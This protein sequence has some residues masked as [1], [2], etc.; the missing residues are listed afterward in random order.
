LYFK[1][2]NKK[3]EICIRRFISVNWS[4]YIYMKKSLNPIS[5]IQRLGYVRK[6]KRSVLGSWG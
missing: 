6:T 3:G 4:N 1:K 5:L 2:F